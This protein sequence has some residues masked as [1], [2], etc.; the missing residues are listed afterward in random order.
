MATRTTLIP[1]INSSNKISEIKSIN[2]SETD[3]TFNVSSLNDGFL[4]KK[5]TGGDE[6]PLSSKKIM[7][8]RKS[9]NSAYHSFSTDDYSLT[10]SMSS[11]MDKL[12]R[13][14]YLPSSQNSTDTQQKLFE[15]STRYYNRFKTLNPNNILQKAFPHVFFV[16]PNCNILKDT[17]T[18]RDE[19]KSN[20]TFMYTWNSA[21]SAVKELTISNGSP[22]DFMLSLSS[23][24]ASFSLSDE[25]INTDT[26]GRTFTGY[27]VAYGKNDIES[28]T[29]GTFEI[30][31]ND[32]HDL[33]IYQIHRLWVEYIN[34][35]YRGSIT[36]AKNSI[37]NKIL[38]YTSAVYYIL[39]AE[40][41]ETILFWSKY[42]GV[43]PSTIPSSQYSWGEGNVVTDTKLNV[44]YQY[45]FKEDFNPYSIL[46]FNYN[47]KVSGGVAYEPTYNTE[48]GHCGDTWV[49]S[50]FIEV[51]KDKTDNTYE[52]KL[53]FKKK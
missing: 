9:A 13:T 1:Y 40:D 49:G 20:E 5:L 41:G 45:S 24:A 4:S 12:N 23:A 27:K 42:Y 18:L 17:N 26:Y 35:V 39:T 7:E 36:P 33:H 3:T 47:S 29:A 53:R 14:L 2:S 46:E 32:T 34:G 22:D 50:P 8:N 10:E 31:F 21:P 25:Y 52:Y 19:L 30:T 38:D 51:I 48:L 16:R 6:T 28:K 15:K 43:F 44:T 11:I 37:I